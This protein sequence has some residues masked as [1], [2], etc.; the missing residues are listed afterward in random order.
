[1]A[2]VEAKFALLEEEGEILSRHPS[3]M[4]EPGL[5]EAPEPLDP[6]EM[7]SRSDVLVPL[8]G[9]PFV[10]A[11]QLQRD[12]ALEFIGVVDTSS[13]GVSLDEGVERLPLAVR[14]GEGDHLQSALVDAKDDVLPMRSPTALPLAMAT[15]HRLIQLLRRSVVE[16]LP[17]ETEGPL[18]GGQVDGDVPAD[19]VGRNSQDEEVEQM[20][21]HLQG[22]PYPAHVGTGELSKLVAAG[23]ALER[24]RTQPVELAV[25]APRTGAPSAPAQL[26]EKGPG[27][28]HADCQLQWPV[29]EHLPSLLWSQLLGYYLNLCRTQLFVRRD[30][31]SGD[32]VL[33][34]LQRYCCLE[35]SV[36]I[37]SY[38]LSLA[39]YAD[40]DHNDLNT[41]SR[42]G[43]YSLN[44][45][46]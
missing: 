46:L 6:V 8:V 35:S 23:S 42:Y 5:G 34:V 37:K 39:V 11:P 19:P 21:N 2:M 36:A 38:F 44:L 13:L 41:R 40:D 12:V 15:E 26:T 1:M 10:L 9:D 14:H 29:I 43:S 20:S 7:D 30:C 22:D 45:D 28:C 25:G 4:V 17:K 16:G 32:E 27:S 3:V 24:V 18:H 33:S 31:N